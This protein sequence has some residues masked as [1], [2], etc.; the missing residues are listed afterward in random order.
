MTM[1]MAVPTIADA[2]PTSAAVATA[3]TQSEAAAVA[4]E[5]K[6]TTRRDDMVEHCKTVVEMTE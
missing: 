3:A 4:P 2:A 6:L 1:T 5:P